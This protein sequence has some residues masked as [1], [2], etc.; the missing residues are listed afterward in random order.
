MA[1]NVAKVTFSFIQNVYG[2][3][4]S[5]FLDNPSA[6][7]QAELAK[8]EAL[9]A[10]RAAMLGAQGTIQAVK[11]SN[12][13]VA[14]DVIVGASSYGGNGAKPS[15][16][17]DTAVLIKRFGPTPVAQAPLYL[18]GI[19]DEVV[20][21]GG[22]FDFSNGPF[23]AAYN[24]W[25]ALLVSTPLGWGFLAKDPAGS[26]E[27]PVVTV[28]QNTNG[29]VSISCTDNIFN[30]FATGDEVKIFVSGVTGA[31]AINGSN[32]A[33][34]TLP[35]AVTTIKRIPIFP[36][37]SGGK[38]SFTTPKFYK[39]ANTQINRVVE[40]KAGRPLYVSVGRRPARVLA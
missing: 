35:N 8:G 13:Q 25:K 10:K 3:T 33:A 29:T 38:I 17:P 21:E 4:E 24:A 12:E 15:D 26:D 34:V 20:K 28:S 30:A 6:D 27:S 18:R 11:V 14:R 22:V 31:A 39:I 19:W 5:Y 7:L 32:I 36:Y 9:A 40:R 16:A 1:L 2:W 37:L 23:L